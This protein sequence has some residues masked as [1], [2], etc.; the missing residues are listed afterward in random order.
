MA[1]FLI[2]ADILLQPGTLRKKEESTHTF[3][4][5]FFLQIKYQILAQ[6][7]IILVLLLHTEHYPHITRQKCPPKHMLRRVRNENI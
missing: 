5:R 2:A 4:Q 3:F 1:G 7:H 6:I